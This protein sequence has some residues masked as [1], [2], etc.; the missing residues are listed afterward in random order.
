MTRSLPYLP[1]QSSREKTV[2]TKQHQEKDCKKSTS[3]HTVGNDNSDPLSQ[4]LT[5][6]T[7]LFPFKNFHGWAESLEVVSGGHWVHHLP[8][9]PGFWLKATFLSTNICLSWVL[10]FK[11]Q[12]ARPEFGNTSPISTDIQLLVLFLLFTLLICIEWPAQVIPGSGDIALNQT[13]MTLAL[14]MGGIRP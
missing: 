4:W 3:L 7:S 1:L 5:E 10:I 2:W 11:Q 9:L 12:A 6:I 8:R 13:L 14:N